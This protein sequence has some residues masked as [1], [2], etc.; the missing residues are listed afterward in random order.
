M[1]LCMFYQSLKFANQYRTNNGRKTETLTREAA[2]AGLSISIRKSS[3]EYKPTETFVSTT[4][5]PSLLNNNFE[6]PKNQR[7]GE[8]SGLM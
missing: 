1:N 8:F 6:K 7:K 4:G 3:N 2:A 5:H